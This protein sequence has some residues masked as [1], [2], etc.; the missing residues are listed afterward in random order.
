MKPQ[1]NSIAETEK[2]CMNNKVFTFK[3]REI[4]CI[5]MVQGRQWRGVFV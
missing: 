2:L 4:K 5:Q 3:V 1:L